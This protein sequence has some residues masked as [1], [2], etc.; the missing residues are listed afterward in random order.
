MRTAKKTMLAAFAATLLLALTTANASALRSLEFSRTL[1][2][3]LSRALTFLG[4]LEVVCEVGFSTTLNSRSKAKTASAVIGR[5]TAII[6]RCSRGTAAFLN[7]LWNLKYVSISGTLPR[8]SGLT[9]EIERWQLRV[10]NILTC[11]ITAELSSVQSVVPETGVIGNLVG[12]PWRLRAV[13]TT[14]ACEAAEIAMLGTFEPTNGPTT[15]R[16]V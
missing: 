14:G 10:T 16:L 12:R 11:L 9:L 4:I 15:I 1:V 13:T 2:N 6:L 3:L 7:T 5:V 8:I